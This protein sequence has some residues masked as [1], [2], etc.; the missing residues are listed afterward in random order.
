MHCASR[1]KGEWFSPKKFMEQHWPIVLIENLPAIIMATAVL[2]GV[3]K[4]KAALDD[5]HAIASE[6]NLL[7]GQELRLRG[8]GK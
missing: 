3:F 6:Q 7:K 8:E 4:G 1:K 2:V 5:R